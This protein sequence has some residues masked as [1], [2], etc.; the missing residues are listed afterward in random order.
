MGTD[1]DVRAY[2]ERG[3]E[4]GRLLGGSGLLELARTQDIVRRRLPG[5]PARVLD[6]G[7]GAGV[8]AAWL[9][10]DGHRVHLVDPIELHVAQA[11]E[12]AAGSFTAAVGDARA[13]EAA[14]ASVDAVLLLGPL[15]H[16]VERDDR[17]TALREAGR[18]VRPGGLVFAG[19][20]SRFASLFDGLLRGFIA[21]PDFRAAL[22][23]TLRDGRHTNPTGRPAWFTNAYFHHPDELREEVGAAGL[24]VAEVLAVE[25]PGIVLG[26]LGERWSDPWWRAVV[27]DAC[28]AVEAEPSLLGSAGHLMAVGRRPAA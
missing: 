7:G 9:A 6:V 26:D 17:L 10:A 11:V 27:F 28:R 2:Y 1:P 24:D 22:A 19:A 18:V 14:D 5:A 3:R 25:G 4:A 21:E 13:L 16:L 23:G 20:I 12:T 8:H 15:Y